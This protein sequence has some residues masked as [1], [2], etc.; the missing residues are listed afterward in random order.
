MDPRVTSLWEP[1]LT[2]RDRAHL[3]LVGPPRSGG[4]GSRPALL[5]IDNYYRVFGEDRRP[6]LEGV[7]DNRFYLGAEAW[8]AITAQKRLLDV[9]REIGLPVIHATGDPG[10]PTSG[11]SRRH[12]ELRGSAT[13][14]PLPAPEDFRIIDE[15]APIEHEFVI[16]KSAP[17]AFFGTT[18]PALTQML[19]LD[20]VIACG[21]ST[22]GCVRASAVD[23]ASL[24]L[25]VIVPADCV[26]DRHEAAHAMSLFD[27]AQKYGSVVMS[28]HLID[29]LRSGHRREAAKAAAK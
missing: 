9:A 21:E 22:S 3:A 14:W 6:L 27:I 25:Q 19:D 18:L 5:L 26:Y 17:S 16:T 28:D 13:G 12:P 11:G 20:T 15:L 23:A 10:M 4:L 7:S 1:F 29:D 8:P 24:R 2:S